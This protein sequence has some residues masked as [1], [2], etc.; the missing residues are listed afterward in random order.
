VALSMPHVQKAGMHCSVQGTYFSW[1]AQTRLLPSGHTALHVV[2]TQVVFSP[3]WANPI[4]A[5][6]DSPMQAE[7]QQIT[8][9]ITDAISQLPAINATFSADMSDTI[10]VPSPHDWASTVLRWLRW[11]GWQ[12]WAWCRRLFIPDFMILF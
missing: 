9:A 11:L 6:V 7:L 4:W 12:L 8:T 1:E 10:V 5:A 2:Q 3:Q